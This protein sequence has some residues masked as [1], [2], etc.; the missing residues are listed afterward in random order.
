VLDIIMMPH[1]S[2]VQ[3]WTTKVTLCEVWLRWKGN[4]WSFCSL[5]EDTIDFFD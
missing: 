2:F 4:L 5:D 1:P 3:I